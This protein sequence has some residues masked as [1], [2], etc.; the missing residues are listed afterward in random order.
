MTK[1]SHTRRAFFLQGGATLGAG[2]AAT[3]GAATLTHENEVA[4]S[5]AGHA[6]SEAIRGLHHAFVA[7]VEA[8][9]VPAAIPTHL[10][11][12]A[13]ARQIED[14][15]EISADGAAATAT[16]HVDVKVA[17]PLEGE[18]TAAQMARLQ[19]HVA[20]LQWQAGVLECSYERSIE[21]WRIA[22]MRYRPT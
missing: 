20:D 14:A 8:Q 3:A 4:R 9:R 13:N 12:R 11:Y 15:L 19:G 16:W 5:A 22:G 18:S 17:T 7:D 6:G 21:G 1:A 2:I 10:A